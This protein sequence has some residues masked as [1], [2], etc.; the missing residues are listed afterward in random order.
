MTHSFL[1]HE[2]LETY[3]LHRRFD[4]MGRLVGDEAMKKL[5]ASHVMVIGLGGVGSYAAEMIVRSGIGKITLIDFDEICI[6][7][8]NRQLHA[9][10]GTVGKQKSAIL[11]ERFRKIN[12][13]AEVEELALF[14]NADHSAQILDLNPDYIID[15]IDSVTSKAH[16]L[17][18]CRERHIKVVSSGGAGG[19][20][21][22]T[23]I[24]TDDLSETKLDPLARSIRKILRTKYGFPDAGLFGIPTVYS[25]EPVSAPMELTYDHGQGFRCV[26]P[27]GDNPFFTCDNRNVIH[28]TAGFVTGAFGF[29]CASLVVRHISQ[30]S[31]DFQFHETTQACI[32]TPSRESL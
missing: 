18:A 28:G 1:Q 8:V 27:Q 31:V 17:A 20:M 12:P 24:R 9:M 29:A 22:P 11:G 23:Q 30:K 14:Y 19:R 10:Q 7:N 2:D 26:C 21:D 32:D 16:L 25:T 4:R 5:M 3:K 15:A 6:T 13:K